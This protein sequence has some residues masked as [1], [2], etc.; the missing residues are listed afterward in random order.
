MPWR[1]RGL[2]LGAWLALA[3]SALSVLLTLVLT[4]VVERTASSGVAQGIGLNLAQLA[5]QTASRMDRGMF[6]RY[7]E[8]Q[9][10]AA[11]VDR[12]PEHGLVHAELDAAK[13]SYR[14]Y[15]WLG[16]TNAE[17]VVQAA[18]GNLLVGQNV[19]QRPWFKQA[20]S[21]NNLG[22][23]HEALLLQKVLAPNATE[24]L[25]FYDVAFPLRNGGVLGAHISWDW[26]AD[27]RQAM[28]GVGARSEGVEPLVVSAQGKVLL[29]PRDLEGTQLKLASLDRATAGERG[30]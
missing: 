21:G 4:L 19:A 9:L 12:L 23:V 30:Y 1:K 22:D 6:E 17:G 20:R 5:T 29:G 10:M 16:A 2:T 25:R 3:F 24:P 15:A 13:A 26:A 14:F 11:R 27:L 28:F 18:S 7:R 8:V